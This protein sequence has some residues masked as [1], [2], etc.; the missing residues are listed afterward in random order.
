[1]LTATSRCGRLHSMSSVLRHAARGGARLALLSCL[2]VAPA[3]ATDFTW[4]PG[5]ESGIPFLPV[6]HSVMDF[7]AV[8]DGVTDDAAAF[9]AALDAVPSGSYGAVE[10]PAGTYL[11]RSTIR[12][13]SGNV[14]R[15][16]GAA[17]THLEFDLAGRAENAIEFVSTS[18]GPWVDAVGG[19][20][21]GST[22]ITVSDASGFSV[23]TFAE[24]HQANDPDVMYTNPY[25]N[26]W[27]AQDA[28]GEVVRVIGASGG[29][30]VLESPLHFSY[31][32]SLAPKVRW[33]N[34]VTYAGLEDLHVR[35]L[36]AGDGHLTMFRNAAWVWILGVESEMASRSH[37]QA[38]TVYGCA[39]RGSY[40]HH[41]HNYGGGGHG[42]G[43]ELLYQTTN[44][45][46]EDNIFTN[47]RHSMMVH[48]G[49]NGNVFA[50]NFSRD[51]YCVDCWTPNDISIHG[52]Y[53]LRN[54]FEGNVVQDI[55]ATDYWG[56]AGPENAYL[57]NCVQ[58]WGIQLLDSSDE[59]LVLGNTLIDGPYGNLTIDSS[60]EGTFAH[61]NYF[62]GAVHWD[63][64]TPDHTI[65]NSLYLADRPWFF[66][67]DPWPSIGGDLGPS[68]CSNP[69]GERWQAGNA[70]PDP[71]IWWEPQAPPPPGPGG[72]PPLLFGD[73][74][75]SGDLSVWSAVLP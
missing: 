70:T 44:C 30:I 27:W 58:S 5:V 40:F 26:Q 3:W 63:P 20:E 67:S 75:D 15:G 35:R 74:F 17:Q 47:L 13:T 36:D 68:A 32:P 69:A 16:Q 18:M 64:A 19:Y 46:V 62:Q 51:G 10:V 72:Q 41:A 6:V 50:Y 4:T 23:P 42:Y 56:P 12:L 43:V 65:P 2:S 53:P 61:G 66:G 24:I 14:L 21:M 1:M 11:I 8:G 7:G 52:H 22:V 39:I 59:Q 37:V 54:L 34:P 45:L 9:Q 60:V 33:L 73:G 28:V 57:R 48:I 31:N 49:A 38:D 55:V 71:T 25:W 29:Q